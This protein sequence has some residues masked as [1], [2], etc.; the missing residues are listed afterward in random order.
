MNHEPT[1][2]SEVENRMPDLRQGQW[3]LPWSRFLAAPLPA[4]RRH[5]HRPVRLRADLVPWRNPA[6]P[7]GTHA[8]DGPASRQD[9]LRAARSGLGSR[10]SV[11]TVVGTDRA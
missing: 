6:V 1:E 5:G 10:A 3:L 7:P 11:G 9:A 2:A 8:E 4:G